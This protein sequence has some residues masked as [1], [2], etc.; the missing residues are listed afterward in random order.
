MPKQST[1]LFVEGPLNLLG[2]LLLAKWIKNQLGELET[3]ELDKLHG[4]FL[5]A[6]S[7][8]L[9]RPV[10]IGELIAWLYVLA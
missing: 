8:G 3:K 5:R 7:S 9:R 10:Q 4:K 1:P 2:V 6:T